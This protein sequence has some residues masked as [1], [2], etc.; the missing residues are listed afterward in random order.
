MKRSGSYTIA[1]DEA[2]CAVFGMPKAAI[3]LGA[4]H[5]V[6]PLGDISAAVVRALPGG[7]RPKDC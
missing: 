1:Q 2:T 6:L 5:Q 3:E 7:I 4:A